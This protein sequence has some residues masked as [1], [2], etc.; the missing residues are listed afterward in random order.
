MKGLATNRVVF[1]VIPNP[2]IRVQFR[3]IGR[4]KE[5][6][7]TILYAFDKTGNPF[8]SMS[9]MP[10]DDQ[11]HPARN[12][13]KKSLDKL[14][15]RTRSDTSPQNH[16]PEF[17][18]STDGRDQIQPKSSPGTAN[19]RRF[20]SCRPCS[21][22]MM[23]GTDPRLISKEDHSLL[24]TGQTLNPGI[25]LL[26]PLLD[27]LRLLLVRSPDRTLR[28]QSQLPQQ[29]ADRG[30][31]QLD[32]KPLINDLSHH[33]RGPERKGKLQLQRILFGYGPID[34]L[35][36][37]AI[38]FGRP[39]PSLFRIQGPP[40]APAIS[41]QPAVDRDSVNSQ[42]LGDDFRTLSFLYTGDSTF[43]QFRQHPIIEF[44]RIPCFHSNYYRTRNT[45]MSI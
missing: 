14:N 2:F 32:T 33:L 23:I 3:R 9:R 29:T 31:T 41:R 17:P 35:Q 24:F 21:T 37:S 13:M 38:Q 22:R 10:V 8:R 25:L 39:S 34:P 1:Q 45:P 19:H 12:A 6:S 42:S 36:S 20:P 5:E 16:K 40:A 4:Q 43:A 30:L 18:L 44:P 26:Q 7:K 28:S 27:F 15:K 11:K